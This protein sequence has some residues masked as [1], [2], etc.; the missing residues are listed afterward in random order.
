MGVRPPP[1]HAD[2]PLHW[3]TDADT[4][5]LPAGW[6]GWWIVGYVRLSPGEAEA[7]GYIYRGPS[8]AT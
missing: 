2:K 4:F 5:L 3:L 1:E 6:D 7:A 8:D